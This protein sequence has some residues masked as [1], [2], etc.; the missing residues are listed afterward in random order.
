MRISD[1]PVVFDLPPA[2]AVKRGDEFS[3]YVHPV[4][5][6][7]CARCHNDH[8]E[9]KFQ[10]VPFKNKQDRT[11]ES[12]RANL[13]AALKLIDR[14]N[15]PRSELLSSSLRPHGR[16]PNAKPIFQGSNDR[17]YQILAA[18]VNNLRVKKSGEPIA[19]ARMGAQG[20]EAGDLFAADRSRISVDAGLPSVPAGGK[21]AIE[22]EVL[23]PL[24]YEKG[25]GL[26]VESKNDPSEFP[27]PFAVSG[28]KPKPGEKPPAARNAAW[29]PAAPG[30]KTTTPASNDAPGGQ[31]ASSVANEAG[32]AA[33]AAKTS[34]AA[35]TGNDPDDS[36]EEASAKKKNRK[37]LKLDP[38]I[39]QRALQMRNQNRKD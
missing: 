37:P 31:K 10:L 18:W 28:V 17:A 3:H 29:T 30:T 1:L 22:A 20:Q 14:E 4:L 12:L 24:R 38:T 32:P 35:G 11:R 33:E 13:D 7:Y 36:S 26:T 27:I 15:P 23:P 8:Y 6:T 25:K 2:Q 5:Q 16:G 21:I 19:A 34:I 9:G 39:L